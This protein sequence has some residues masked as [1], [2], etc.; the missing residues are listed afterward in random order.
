VFLPKKINELLPRSNVK[1]MIRHDDEDTQLIRRLRAGDQRAFDL[2]VEHYRQSV[3]NIMYHTLGR[4]GNADDLAQDIFIKVYNA[5]PSYREQST[6]STWLYRITVNVCI[7]EVRRQKRRKSFGPDRL[8]GIQPDEP[9]G[10]GIPDQIEQQEM[11]EL[12]HDAIA[13][14][15]EPYRT[16]VILRD[17]N[18]LSYEEIAKILKCRIG[19]VKSRL[20]Y[21][22]MTLRRQL[23]KY[24]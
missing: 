2:L 24:L 4:I 3:F 19:T 13:A 7:D 6:F 14:L 11:T 5:L 18:E 15:P 21:A 16:V 20:F 12:I 22:R 17:I 9:A 10:K 1:Y 23:S 8:D